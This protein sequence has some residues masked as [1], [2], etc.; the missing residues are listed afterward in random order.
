MNF[1]PYNVKIIAQQRDSE[2]GFIILGWQ[3]CV[4]V[5]KHSVDH[6]FQSLPTAFCSV[7]NTQMIS[8]GENMNKGGRGGASFGTKT[9]LLNMRRPS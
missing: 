7:S 8:A 1:S 2:P 3:Q 9:L 4:S 6:Q 5:P